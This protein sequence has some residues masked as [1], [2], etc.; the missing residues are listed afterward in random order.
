MSFQIS[1]LSVYSTRQINLNFFNFLHFFIITF[2]FSMIVAIVNIAG[3]AIALHRSG[4]AIL[5]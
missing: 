2:V 4:S 1:S 5:Q 3:V